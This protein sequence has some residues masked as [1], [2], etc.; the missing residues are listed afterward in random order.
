[1]PHDAATRGIMNTSRPARY[2]NCIDQCCPAALIA[3]CSCVRLFQQQQQLY[4]ELISGLHMRATGNIWRCC[5]QAHLSCNCR[6][7]LGLGAT[8]LSLDDARLLPYQQALKMPRQ[9]RTQGPTAASA[10]AQSVTGFRGSG[11]AAVSSAT[12][13]AGNQTN[14][15]QRR[16]HNMVQQTAQHRSPRL[17]SGCPQP[18]PAY[19][20]KASVTRTSGWLAAT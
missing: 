17:H 18:T 1:M 9:S 16:H 2:S 20:H 19:Q 13:V 10:V 14:S 15:R 3:I 6:H 8:P 5:G 4:V 12:Y 11:L 7:G